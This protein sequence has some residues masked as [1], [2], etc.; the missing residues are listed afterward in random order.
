MVHLAV[1]EAMVEQWTKDLFFCNPDFTLFSAQRL[2]GMVTWS[3]I[4]QERFN[5]YDVD[6]KTFILNRTTAPTLNWKNLCE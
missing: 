3:E 2:E 1:I 4:K 5:G 6:P